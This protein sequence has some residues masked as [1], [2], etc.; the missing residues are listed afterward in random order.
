MAA[1][2]I[3]AFGIYADRMSAGEAVDALHRIGF[4][5]ADTSILVPDNIGT[6]DFSHEKHTKALQGAAI[7]AAIGIAVG[8]CL[9][10][11]VSTG[12]SAGISWLAHF[13]ALG[14]FGAVLSGAGVGSGVGLLIGALIGSAIP[15]Y[16][17]IRYEG[18]S[19]KGGVLLSIHCDNIDWTRR[20]KDIMRQTGAK[21]I[22]L[23]GEA[24]ADFGASEKPMRRTR[25]IPVLNT[26]DLQSK[27]IE[28]RKR[29]ARDESAS[30]PTIE[31]QV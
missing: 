5:N 12:Q 16:E 22:A 28:A 15:E 31:S 1:R 27:E 23:K 20:A 29:R 7:G 13:A 24:K 26:P 6:K 4:R 17:A 18:R 9:G 19:R 21:D 30:I 14:T 25:L 3:A 8:C 2:N 11:L 10:W